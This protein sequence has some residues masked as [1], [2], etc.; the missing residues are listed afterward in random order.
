MSTEAT[1]A[2][3]QKLVIEIIEARLS[4]PNLKAIS[5]IHIIPFIPQEKQTDLMNLLR[6]QKLALADTHK[7]HVELFRFTQ[8]LEAERKALGTTT[9]KRERNDLAHDIRAV[10]KKIKVKEKEAE[11]SEK[12]SAKALHKVSALCTVFNAEGAAR[13]ADLAEGDERATR[14]R[15]LLAEL[16]N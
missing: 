7:R 13:L 14:L 16:A 4:A 5:D 9:D 2:E 1:K 8:R 15:A 11:E 10:E 6:E 12:Q 3:A